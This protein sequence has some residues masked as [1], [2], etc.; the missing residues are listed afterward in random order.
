[1]QAPKLR[2]TGD[3]VDAGHAGGVPG[4]SAVLLAAPAVWV[5]VLR[6]CTG[7]REEAVVR[8]DCLRCWRAVRFISI[9]DLSQT[10]SIVQDGW[11]H[12]G[13]GRAVRVDLFEH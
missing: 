7:P 4:A 1:M 13:V 12:R 6:C 9:S 8:C 3:Q 5:A 10:R 2:I 11:R